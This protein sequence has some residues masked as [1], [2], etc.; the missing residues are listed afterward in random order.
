MSMGTR[1]IRD[2][3]L[4]LRNFSRM[5][6]AECKAVDIHDGIESTLLILQHRF[7]SQSERPT[8][9]VVK[10]FGTLRQIECFAGQL[11]QVFMNIISNAIDALETGLKE[12]PTAQ[13]NPKIVL[14]TE[15][16]ADN[17]VI[18]ISDNGAGM[19]TAVKDRIFDP[20]FTTKPV[21]T[22]TG[23]GMAISHQ[24]VVEK[25]R[26]EIACHSEEGV[27]TTFTITLPVRL[28]P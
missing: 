9:E 19:P 8:I 26:G 22:G 13:E 21:G 28:K 15:T 24:L 4:S 27:G 10:E 12:N 7:K 23:M 2:I 17:I 6:E 3:V 16:C 25:H 1:R 5:D 20:F 14:R 11:N 18:S